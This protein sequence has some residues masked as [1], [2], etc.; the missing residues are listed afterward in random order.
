MLKKLLSLTLSF[1]AVIMHIPTVFAAVPGDVNA[2]GI[3]SS[4]DARFILRASVN[5]E[6]LTDEQKIEGDTY[7]DGKITAKD[8]RIILRA[9]VE[10]ET[11]LPYAEREDNSPPP[12]SAELS[13]KNSAALIYSVS[14]QKILFAN[15]PD[16]KIP[17]ASTSKLLTAIVALTYC[18]PDDI[19]TV[20]NEAE[21][22]NEESSECGIKK[23]DVLTMYD[24]LTGLLVSSGNDAAYS[25]AVFTAEKV[26]QDKT[27][28]E[29]EA[30]EAFCALMNEKAKSLGMTSSS[31]STPDGWDDEKHYSTVRD[32][33]TLTKYA[34]SFD[35]IREI[36]SI[37]EKEVTIISGKKFTWKNTN[38]L[39]RPDCEDFYMPEAAGI[40]TGMTDNAGWCTITNITKNGK[41]Y[42]LMAFGCK[43][44]EDRYDI[45]KEMYALLENNGY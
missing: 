27:F 17:T 34:L 31:F 8:A 23:N 43:E 7:K 21:M 29:D 20:G 41:D 35:I 6:E 39:L 13:I 25:V 40:K 18:S 38:K 19:V 1:L 45:I 4:E 15:N 2:D 26:Y 16:K 33:L 37:T 42:I 30:V 36:T 5:L 24:L 28:T 9:A 3:V 32:L 12:I 14:D 44:Q 11:I 22:I 10:L